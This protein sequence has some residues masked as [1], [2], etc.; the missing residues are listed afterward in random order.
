MSGTLCPSLSRGSPLVFKGSTLIVA[1]D[2]SSQLAVS[3]LA[4]SSSL[5]L[6]LFPL[7]EEVI[8]SVTC[9][10]RDDPFLP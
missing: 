9:A 6:L 3:V 1:C 4:L 2:E 7:S 8:M 5:F 10:T